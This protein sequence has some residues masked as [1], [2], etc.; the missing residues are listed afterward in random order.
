MRALVLL[1]L[2]TACGS[3][4]PPSTPA[5]ATPAPSLSAAAGTHEELAPRPRDPEPPLATRHPHDV[6]APAGTRN[7]PYYWLRDDTRKDPAMLAYLAAEQRYTE[8]VMAP[9]AALEA[10]LF[11]ELKARIA[12]DDTSVPTFDNGYWYYTRYEAG[13]QQPIHA[14]RKATMSAPEEVLVDGNA[15]AEGHRFYAI[16]GLAVSRDNKLVAWSDDTVGRRQYTLHVRELATG[17]LL[18]DTADNI[19]EGVEWANDNKTVFVVGKDATTLRTDRIFRIQLGAAPVQ[20]FIEPDGSYDVGIEATKS[21]RYV[22]IAEN[23]ETNDHYLIIDANAPTAAPREFSPRTND[24]LFSA[25]HVGNRWVMRTNDGAKN[26]RIV[27][28]AD[29]KQ[30]DHRA[31]KELV[32]ARTDTFIEAVAIYDRFFAATIRSGGLSKV[33]VHPAGKA[34]YVLETPDPAYAMAVI[35]TPDA[36]ASAVRYSY[37]SLVRPSSE[38]EADVQTKTSKLLKQQPVPTYDPALYTSEYV[39]ATAA[40]GA[41]IPISI[42]YKTTTKRDGTAPLLV[43]GYGSYGFSTDP[44]FRSSA[45]SLLDRGWI[46]AIA[47]VRGGQELGRAWYDDGHLTH[48]KNTFTDFI[49]ATE[50]LVANGY[51]A[52]DQVFAE[53]GSAGGL[54]MGA[55]LNMR[56]D[57]YRGVAAIVPFVDA[58]TTMLDDSIPLTTNE[59]TEWGDPKQP[60]AYRYM[61]SYSPYDNV[62]AQAYPSIFVHTGLWDSQVQYYEPTKWVAK[63][64]MTKTDA[65]PVVLDIDMTSGHDGASGRYDSLRQSARVLAFFEMVRERPDRRAR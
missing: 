51:A 4:P 59:F 32:P 12:E 37:D 9:A 48:K 62:K 14:R 39:H 2:V 22:L 65:N 54:L 23:A 31:W 20:I 6:V 28:V 3:A 33:E 56:P 49:A 15:L 13:K 42:V 47:H 18:P 40:D 38:Y 34:A 61:L 35:D 29:G 55:I 19:G 11:S 57:L 7:D 41:S 52:K 43:Y 5:S 8:E 21:H 17:K 30:A 16:G 60:E 63:L 27:E 44:S 64:R 36:H 46:Y 53:G 50:Y 24:T 10:K 45:I 1:S 58:V 26:F 25:D